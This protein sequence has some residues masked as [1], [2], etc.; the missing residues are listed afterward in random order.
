MT[1]W[2]A[3]RVAR[4]A[5]TRKAKR[6]LWRCCGCR[7][8]FRM[9]RRWGAN[10]TLIMNELVRYERRGP[11]AVLTMNRPDKRNALSRDLIAYLTAAFHEA[12]DDDSVRCVILTGSGP[13]FCAGMDLDEL[14]GT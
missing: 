1:C 6:L 13:A 4:C 8:T 2:P 5:P 11:A 10:R 14:R 3:A 7:S 9:R 12:W